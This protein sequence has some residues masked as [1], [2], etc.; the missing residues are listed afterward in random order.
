M[1]RFRT[2]HDRF[3]ISTLPT[4]S[5]TNSTPDASADDATPPVITGDGALVSPFREPVVLTGHIEEVF[6]ER[7][8]RRLRRQAADALGRSHQWGDRNITILPAKP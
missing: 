1:A 6:F 8:R 7:G 3:G 2:P 4:N 5:T